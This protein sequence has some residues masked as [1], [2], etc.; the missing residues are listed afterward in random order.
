MIARPGKIYKKN[1]SHVSITGNWLLFMIRYSEINIFTIIWISVAD[2]IFC[3]FS[4]DSIVGKKYRTILG[5]SVYNNVIQFSKEDTAADGVPFI[6]F[7]WS[8]VYR[9][10]Y[11]TH[12]HTYIQSF[13]L[14]FVQAQILSL[15]ESSFDSCLQLYEPAGLNNI[16]LLNL[17][18]FSRLIMWLRRILWKAKSITVSRVKYGKNHSFSFH[19]FLLVLFIRMENS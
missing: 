17:V 4:I 11:C 16:Y 19:Q 8:I 15:L 1:V 18:S 6:P 12:I 2:L 10:A 7:I 14:F 9:I 5:Y 3:I 13:G